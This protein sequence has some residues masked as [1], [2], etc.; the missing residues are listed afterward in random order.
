MERK[1]KTTSKYRAKGS[2]AADRY[3]RYQTI[4]FTMFKISTCHF[5]CL[6]FFSYS[7]LRMEPCRTPLVCFP[8]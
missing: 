2:Y 6:F 8:L 3:T 4:E 5:F 7:V 1:V